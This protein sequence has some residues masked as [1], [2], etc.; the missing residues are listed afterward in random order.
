MRGTLLSINAVFNF[1]NTIFDDLSLPTA[2]NLPAGG[3]WISNPEDY[4]LDGSLLVANILAE[5]GEMNLVYSDPDTLKKMIAIWSALNFNNWLGLWKTLLYDYNPIWNKD[6]TIT[7]S[8]EGDVVRTD[9]GNYTDADTGTDT[10]TNYVTGYDS[11]TFANNT[12]NEL[13]YG[14]TRTHTLND[15]K[16]TLDDNSVRTRK[17]QGNIGVTTTQ[18]MIEEQR[19]IVEFNLYTYITNSFKERFCIM[20]Y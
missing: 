13:G 7:E 6:G 15:I 1:D 17:E 19:K 10:N 14:K 16:S 5:L 8:V 9:T 12:K 3:P 11:N 20:T 4:E 2:T 18:K